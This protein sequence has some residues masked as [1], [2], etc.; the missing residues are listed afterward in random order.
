MKL[1]LTSDLHQWIPKWKDLVALTRQAK[2]RFVLVAGDLLP[3]QGGCTEQRR[4]FPALRRH[5]REMNEAAPLTVLLF[6][7]N[8]DCHIL[9]PLLDELAAEGLCVNLNGRVHR[10]DGLVF[11]G[12]NKV[13]DY[14]FGYKHWCVRDGDYGAC[15]VQYR[16]EGVTVDL[17][18]AFVPLASLADHLASKPSLGEELDRLVAQLDPGEMGR[19]VWMIHQ[20]PS[21]LGMDIC[22]TGQ[23]VGSPTVLR[24]I[25]QH[26]PLLGCSGHI[27]ESPHQPDGQWAAQVGRTLWVQPGQVDRQF[28]YATVYLGRQGR[29][30]SARH[31]LFGEFPAPGAGE[32]G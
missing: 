29:I 11:G 32:A 21:N 23:R 3:K 7:G 8:D 18:G 5:L 13:R 24:F 14:P 2:P 26:Q 31:S 27:H 6:L 4:F 12:M 15:P 28:H 30:E 9:E 17:S 19:S 25:G 20:P 22:G 16:G 1:I 10:E